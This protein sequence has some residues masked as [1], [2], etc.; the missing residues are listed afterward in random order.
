MPV[1]PPDH[2]Q[3][4]TRVGLRHLIAATRGH[5]T[6]IT[7]AVLLTMLGAG[8]GLIQ[9]LMVML[10]IDTVTHGNTIGWL[11]A[12]LAVMFVAEAV[13]DTVGRYWLQRAGE[14]VVLGLRLRLI[15][16]LLRLP[17][18]LY[19]RHRIGDL[20]SRTT[21][22]TTMLRDA[23]AYDVVDMCSG[24]FIVAGGLAAMAWLDLHL[25][26]IVA[27]LV[28][29]VGTTTLFALRGI[30]N[31]TQGAQG[32]LG[33]MSAELERALTAI[34]TVRAMRAEDREHTR[35]ADRAR[36]TYQ[37]NLRAARLESIAGPAVTLAAHG[38]LIIVLILGG[39]RVADG[40]LTLAELVAFLL[41]VSY[42]AMPMAGLFDLAATLQRGL[43]ALQRVHDMTNLPQEPS[44]ARP[45]PTHTRKAA[46]T[47]VAPNT[48]TTDPSPPPPALELRDVWFG[49]HPN[50]PVLRGV[51]FTIPQH[52]HMAL[53][54]RSG[55]G[56]S[57][58]LAL[59]ERFYDPDQGTILLNGQNLHTDLT[60]A[61]ARQ[62]IGLVEQT[63]PIL[64]G[65]LR[66]NITYAT[67]HATDDEI[68]HTLALTNLTDMVN[69]LPDG[70]ETPVGDHGT[71]LSGGERQR[72]AIARALLPRPTLLLLDEPTS[73][74]DPANET[75]FSHAIQH[76]TNHSAL[77]VIAHRDSTIHLADTVI[78]L[79]HGHTTT[80]ASR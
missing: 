59:I 76:I 80:L 37:D 75:A 43:V 24:V 30:R 19:D 63:T 21:T 36:A 2:E 55:A 50:R 13:V 27:A 11:L 69:R 17:M 74:L 5:R 18:R 40:Q 9:P 22:D 25:F 7:V 44:K 52:G 46:T 68:H 23:I 73:H 66:D 53:V 41:Y 64:H 38:S 47:S 33:T 10:T 39:L 31:A 49:Y 51:S 45:C 15:D 29:A 72:L 70:L 78:T 26:T 71:L 42:V 65:T 35:I 48:P 60:I 14:S 34:R 1:S 6:S 62:R 4:H 67:P 8:L 79:E 61:Q 56:K 77:L 58:I 57:T 16:R 28:S 3:P 32:N 20:L 12:L 54:G